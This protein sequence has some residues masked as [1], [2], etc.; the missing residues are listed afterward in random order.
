LSLLTMMLHSLVKYSWTKERTENTL[1]LGRKY[2]PD[3]P[4]MFTIA[5]KSRADSYRSAVLNEGSK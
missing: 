3:N 5:S 2:L 1:V 4:S